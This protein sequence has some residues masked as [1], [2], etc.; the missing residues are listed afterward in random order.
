MKA[1]IIAVGTEL[2]LGEIVN[3]DS[4][5]LASELSKIGIDVYYQSVVGDNEK[6]LTD[7]INTALSRSDIIILSGGLGPTNDD[8]TKETL[9]KA[10][11]AKM[12]LDNE[13]LDNIKSYFRAMN[14]KMTDSNIKQ[15]I[16]PVG[17][18]VF[19]NNNGTAPGGAI[20]KDGKIAIF[21]PGPPNEIRPMY[22]ESVKPYLESKS[23]SVLISK[24]LRII[25]IG[26]STVDEM[27]SDLMKNSKNPTVAP[28]AKTNEVTL[29]ITA[30]CKDEAEG[31][32]MIA[33]IEEQIRSMLGESIYGINDDSLFS[34]V[35]GMLRD[36]NMTVS[37]AESCTGGLLAEKI[38]QVSGASEVFKQSYVTYCDEAKKDILGVKIE[39]LE[40]Y[41]AV[42]EQ[43][44]I[45]M[46]KGALEK[47]KAD[48]ALSV[49][50]VAGPKSDERGNPV[51]LVYIG[52]ADKNDF[53]AKKF[54]FKGSREKIRNSACMNAYAMLREQILNK[55]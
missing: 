28:Y 32:K 10:M 19:K 48:I 1:E 13:S 53:Y 27:L 37:F 31:E 15:A 24:T 38:T 11:G 39:T 12:A 23:D 22:Y 5:F 21:L 36:K 51:G 2:L 4:Q 8:I 52:I 30:K 54:N 55:F 43:T 35:C 25:G 42:S 29:R 9:S 45:E 16:M 46:A 3:T 20:E 41:S 50:G 47:S 33:P 7:T 17:G 14:R 40:K 49:T 6:R 26:E 34:V 18:I 44:A